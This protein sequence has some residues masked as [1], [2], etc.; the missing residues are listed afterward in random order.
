MKAHF[1]YRWPHLVHNT[2]IGRM[3]SCPRG[4]ITI[5]TEQVS[6]GDESK[7]HAYKCVAEIISLV[8][9]L[10]NLKL[11]STVKAGVV[12]RRCRKASAPV[13]QGEGRIIVPKTSFGQTIIVWPRE[14]VDGV[15]YR[16]P[17]KPSCNIVPVHKTK[18]MKSFDSS[19]QTYWPTNS[20]TVKRLKPCKMAIFEEWLS[21]TVE[22]HGRSRKVQQPL[23]GAK[24]LG[25]D[26]VIW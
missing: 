14:M 24:R 25:I 10:P 18:W 11:R 6:M 2:M 3:I 5:K 4:S 19:N 1:V 16:S 26:D 17:S 12:Q 13:T 7:V 23:E 20:G 22:E 21:R 15:L 9:R 8:N